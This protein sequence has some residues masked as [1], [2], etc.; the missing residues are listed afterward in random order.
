[1][2]DDEDIINVRN[3][4][5]ADERAL[6]IHEAGHALVAH[7]LGADLVFVEVYVSRPNPD[8]G[9]MG[10]GKTCYREPFADDVKSLA[11][12]VAGYK[13]ELAFAAD[14]QRVA[15]M[16]AREGRLAGDSKQMHELLFRFPEAERL[17]ALVE[18]FTLADVNLQANEQAVRNIADTLFERR[19][20]DP[21]RIEGNELAGLLA[22]VRS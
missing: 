19:F 12:C 14:E 9:K 13:A 21:A 18:G 17:A 7:A 11:V 8:D 15:K 10:G 5:D 2:T 4:L 1:M 6:T 3:A 16:L 20:T 22:D